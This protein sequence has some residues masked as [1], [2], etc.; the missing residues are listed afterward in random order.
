[1]RASRFKSN[2]HGNNSSMF[3]HGERLEQARERKRGQTFSY[4]E[5]DDVK[6]TGP[7]IKLGFF[8]D[9]GEDVKHLKFPGMEY[10]IGGRIY[11]TDATG[12]FTVANTAWLRDQQSIQNDLRD[13][14]FS[15]L[16]IVMDIE[17]EDVLK[18]LFGAAIW[19]KIMADHCTP[20]ELSV[21]PTDS[22]VFARGVS[23]LKKWIKKRNF[24]PDTLL[25]AGH[26]HKTSNKGNVPDGMD[27]L[28]AGGDA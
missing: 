7:I 2:H 22:I 17:Y 23:N 19:A 24:A 26:Q 25:T 15:I 18:E 21:M 6:N 27:A 5:G 11:K 14:I 10:E 9:N 3:S 8:D 1:M 13:H 28:L 4:K 16:E 20:Q 12:T